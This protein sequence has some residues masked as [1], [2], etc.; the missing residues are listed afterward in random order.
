MLGFQP[1][2]VEIGGQFPEK[3]WKVVVCPATIYGFNFV[4]AGRK[5]KYKK[6]RSLLLPCSLITA[7]NCGCFWFLGFFLRE[8][9]RTKKDVKNF[10]S[11]KILMQVQ[12]HVRLHK[13]WCSAS[14]STHSNILKE[15]L[16]LKPYSEPTKPPCWGSEW[17]WAICCNCEVFVVSFW[18]FLCLATDIATPNKEPVQETNSTQRSHPSWPPA[19]P[20]EGRSKW[21]QEGEKF[22]SVRTK[23]SSNQEPESVRNGLSTKVAKD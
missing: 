7:W 21:R 2:V 3:W 8:G 12:S 17:I 1:C 15:A 16:R 20:P 4:N 5:R 9:W 19:S 14:H 10:C 23:M 13:N 6:C 22:K 18:F 11:G